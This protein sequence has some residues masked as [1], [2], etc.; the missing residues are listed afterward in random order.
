MPAMT[1][2]A[3]LD[4]ELLELVSSLVCLLKNG[5]IDFVNHAGARMLGLNSQAE[6]IGTQFEDFVVSDYRF[7]MEAGWELLAEEEFLPLKLLRVDGTAFEAELRVRRAQPTSDIFLLEVR[8]IS[9][10][11]KSAEALREREERL[12][13]VLASVA[14]GIVTINDSGRIESANPAADRMFGY[15]RG[16]LVGADL[17]TL[18]PEADRERHHRFFDAYMAGLF[19]TLM[20]RQV[21]G[22]GQ[23]ADGTS[24]PM[25]I[26]VSELRHGRHRLFTAI[27]RDISERKENE[28]RIRRL[29]HHDSLTGLP[30]RNLLN[31]RMRHAL[32]RAQRNKSRM[33]LLYVDLDKFKPINDTL[34]HEAGDEV[35]REVAERLNRC[36]RSSDTVSRVGGDEFVVLLETV[37][38]PNEAALVARKIID[39]LAKPIDYKGN[40]CQVGASIGGAVYPDDGET[41]DEISKAADI[42]MYRVKHAGRNDFRFYSEIAESELD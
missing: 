2:T 11:V 29:A 22:L 34:G 15:A 38:R 28:E 18:L 6:A 1:T 23:R 10:F 40:I 39:S 17:V 19:P 5:K 24:F 30:N 42:A 4:H 14:E 13:G 37:A 32:A 7:L 41:M 16:K 35:L 9:K 33:A 31:D 8:D 27:L 25:E 21:E 20:G 26:S 12:Q 36:V 3:M